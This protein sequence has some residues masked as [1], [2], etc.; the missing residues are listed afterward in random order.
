LFSVDT[1]EVTISPCGSPVAP[2]SPRIGVS[3]RRTQGEPTKRSR[4]IANRATMSGC[5]ASGGVTTVRRRSCTSRSVGVL[6]VAVGC[7]IGMR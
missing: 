1:T 3:E 7:R 4:A 2:V 5:P 6:T